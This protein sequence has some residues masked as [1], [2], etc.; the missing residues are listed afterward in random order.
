MKTKEHYENALN[1]ILDNYVEVCESYAEDN[2]MILTDIAVNCYLVEKHNIGKVAPEK[3]IGDFV[4]IDCYAPI[5]CKPVDSGLGEI[6][7]DL[8]EQYQR[9]MR[10]VISEYLNHCNNMQTS[11]IR[12]NSFSVKLA[13]GLYVCDPLTI[14][15]NPEFI[16]YKE[17]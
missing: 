2:G 3:V 5:G 14:E 15:L 16:R 12:L 4:I 17:L 9:Q 7:S 8:L 10:V 6:N 13:G 11:Q 1:S